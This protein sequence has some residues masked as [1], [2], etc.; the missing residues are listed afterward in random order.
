VPCGY[1]PS[2]ITTTSSAYI[3]G[4]DPYG[5]RYPTV[6]NAPSRPDG[7]LISNSGNKYIIEGQKKRLVANDEALN[8]YNFNRPVCAVSTSVANSYTNLYPTMYG[9]EGTLVTTTG[10]DGKIYIIERNPSYVFVKRWIVSADSYNYYGFSWSAYRSWPASVMNAYSEV[11]E[12]VHP[13]KSLWPYIWWKNLGYDN[14]DLGTHVR[15]EPGSTSGSWDIEIAQAK[16]DWNVGPI[17]PDF[18]DDPTAPYDVDVVVDDFSA[19]WSGQAEPVTFDQVGRV[20]Q[21][22]VRLDWTDFPGGADMSSRTN[23]GMC[24]SSDTTA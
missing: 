3:N 1:G 20:T 8:S 15:Y 23:W 2:H 12:H 14:N 21:F 18:F 9:R 6:G 4:S 16:G 24:C 19:S 10:G 7:Y 5:V 13:I 11:P 22:I 17:T